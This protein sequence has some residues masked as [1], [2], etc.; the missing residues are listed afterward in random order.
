[1]RKE[2]MG[3]EENVKERNIGEVD[4]EREDGKRGK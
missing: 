4:E 3:D 1:M 2:R